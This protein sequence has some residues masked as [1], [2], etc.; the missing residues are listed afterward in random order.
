MR[1][2]QAEDVLLLGVFGD[3][4]DDAVVGQQSVARRKLLL[5]ADV[6]PISLVKQQ[7]ATC[8][9][10]IIN[11]FRQ[12]NRLFLQ[13]SGKNSS[14]EMLEVKHCREALLAQCVS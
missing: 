2:A 8:G 5:S 12:N 9:D 11:Y 13:H 4:L 7:S 10:R 1:V 6:F 3:G 14:V